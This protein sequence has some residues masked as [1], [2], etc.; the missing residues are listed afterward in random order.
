MPT[1]IA[2][3][4]KGGYWKTKYTWFA[5]FMEKVGRKFFTSSI[6]GASTLTDYPS[7]LVWKH[8]LNDDAKRTNYYDEVGGS[9]V[10]VSFNDRVSSNKIYKSISLEGTSNIQDESFN[11][12]VV[13]ADNNPAKQFSM[14]RI[15]DKGGILYGH[16]GL[17]N[18]LLDG[19]NVKVIGSADVSSLEEGPLDAIVFE[20]GDYNFRQKTESVTNNSKFLFFSNNSFYNL[21]FQEVSL[22]E[23]SSFAEVSADIASLSSSADGSVSFEKVDGF[24]MLLNPGLQTVNVIEIT[25]QE[26]NGAPPRGQYAQADIVLG[27]QPYELYAINVNYEPTDLDHSK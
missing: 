8:N 3:S 18:T 15:K 27:S 1:T 20:S 16:I 9:G 21:D 23:G 2:Y 25:P 22:S 13:N 4:N 6:D 24:N 12:F 14:G 19:S 10:S 17:S 7:S 11:T 5:S 26:I